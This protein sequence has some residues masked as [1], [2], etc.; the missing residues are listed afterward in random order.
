MRRALIIFL[1]LIVLGGLTWLIFIKPKNNDA[2]SGTGVFDS[3]FPIGK[4]G[5]S[6][7]DI[8][9][10]V[11]NGNSTDITTTSNLSR[12]TPLTIR[13]VAGLT[14]FTRPVTVTIPSDDPKIQSR[15]ETILEHVIRYIS[16]SNGYVYEI[17]ERDTTDGQSSQISN[18]FIP[19]IYEGYFA[20]TNKT[21]VLRFLRDDNQTI[22]TYTVPIPDANPD[23]TRTQKEGTYLPNNI[24]TMAVSPNSGFLARLT[25]EQGSG[26]LTSS[27]T[28]GVNKKEILRTPFKDWIVLWPTQ[29]I[30]YVQTKASGTTEGFL[31]AVQLDKSLKK[32]VGNVL[33]LTASVSP[34]GAYVLYSQTV[35][36]SF[37]TKLLNTK[38]GTTLGLN[39]SILPEKCVWLKNEDLICAGSDTAPNALYPDSWYNGTVSLTDNLYRISTK[40]STFDAIYKAEEGSFD[41]TNLHVDEDRGFLYFINKPTGVLWKFKL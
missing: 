15:K 26:V 32:I 22:A 30:P 19:N 27:N 35:H 36:D 11:N 10:L 40:M 9:G 16:R 39:L 31:Y 3:F 24:L 41:M 37:T 8:N 12:F 2:V 1:A 17:A 25:F 14:T 29:T 4:N 23:N 7:G 13:P 20:D 5:N 38:T 6:T 28:Q 34:S 21:A 33:G 18:I